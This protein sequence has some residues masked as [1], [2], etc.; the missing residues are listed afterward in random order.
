MVGDF[1]TD[2]SPQVE[3]DYGTEASYGDCL[4]LVTRV[5]LDEV[6]TYAGPYRPIAETR[7]GTFYPIVEGYKDTIAAGMRVESEFQ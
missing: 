3:A 7:L 5:N 1:T 2:V 6:T 4:V